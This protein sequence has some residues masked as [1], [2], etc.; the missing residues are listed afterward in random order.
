L[1]EPFFD[2]DINTREITVPTHFKKYG[3]G[4]QGDM[5]AETLLFK[6]DRYV[7]YIDL[8]DTE[9]WVQ[10]EKPGTDGNA[11]KIEFTYLPA[12]EPEKL[13]FAWPIT[14]KATELSGNLK[15]SVRFIKRGEQD[16]I[17]YSLNT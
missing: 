4:I 7:D 12:E 17:V 3:I 15:F 11:S 2:V 9:I 1:D 6:T 5:I 16:S 8:K 13:I 14:S 10:W